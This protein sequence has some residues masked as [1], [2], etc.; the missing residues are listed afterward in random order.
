[1][2]TVFTERI[3][4]LEDEVGNILLEGSGVFFEYIVGA[5]LLG[6]FR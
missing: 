2:S 1:M 6:H 3:P 5:F 4:L